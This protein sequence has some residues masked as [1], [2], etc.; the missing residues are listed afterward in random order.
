L[1]IFIVSVLWGNSA[2]SYWGKR[3]MKDNFVLTALSSALAVSFALVASQAVAEIKVPLSGTVTL[4]E[5]VCGSYSAAIFDESGNLKLV[6]NNWTCLGGETGGGETGGGETGGGETGGGETGGGETGGGDTT[7]DASCGTIPSGI[8]TKFN[9]PWSD[10]IASDIRNQIGLKGAN[11]YS[12]KMNNPGVKGYGSVNAYNTTKS[13]GEKTIVISECPGSLVPAKSSI[14]Y[15]NGYNACV[16]NGIE[17][18]VSWSYHGS[19][20]KGSSQCRLDPSKQYYINIS[21]VDSAGQNSCS[22][23]EC[24]FI[25]SYSPRGKID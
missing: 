15:A 22:G 10:T 13:G 2:R 18:V 1:F 6:G 9:H 19:I 4:G 11:A 3:T 24:F 14:T 21:H 5:T 16:N 8:T 17:P 12:L 7:V 25:Y 23:P 20:P